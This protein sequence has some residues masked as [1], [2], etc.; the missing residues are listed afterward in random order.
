MLKYTIC[1]IKYHD[2]LLLLNRL[3]APWMGSWNGVGGKL[4]PNETPQA[5][6]I[7]E[8]HEET[9]IRLDKVTARGEMRWTNFG[10]AN[11]GMY[12]FTAE[13]TKKPFVGPQVS[14]EGLLDF[15]TIEWVLSPDNTGVV[16]NIKPLLA[17]LFEAEP[18]SIYQADY[19]VNNLIRFVKVQ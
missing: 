10:T 18:T 12:L 2:S 11:G 13:L 14:I 8:I 16:N 7:R 1:F 3:K 6:I 5:C 19:E 15:K 4:E 17:T 9:G